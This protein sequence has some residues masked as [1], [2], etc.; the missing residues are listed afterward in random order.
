[1]SLNELIGPNSARTKIVAT[2][3]PA[4]GDVKKLVEL[5]DAGVDVFRVNMAHG[6][7]KEHNQTVANIRKRVIC[8]SHSG[9]LGRSKQRG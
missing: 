3:G 9:I 6:N 2:V 1:M 7:R 5:I 4:S 8:T